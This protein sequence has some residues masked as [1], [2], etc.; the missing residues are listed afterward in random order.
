MSERK[1]GGYTVSQVGTLHLKLQ[2]LKLALLR[3]KTNPK[4]SQTEYRIQS[5]YLELLAFS[6]QWEDLLSQSSQAIL[7]C[8]KTEWNAQFYRYWIEALKETH[9]VEGLQRLGKH[10]LAL[11]S[12]SP[13]YQALACI[14]FVLCGRKKFGR[15]LYRD[16]VLSTWKTK[17]HWLVWEAM[18]VWLSDS[19]EEKDR[20][21]G[22]SLYLGLSKRKPNNYLLSR[23][24]LESALDSDEWEGAASVLNAMARA[25]PMAPEYPLISAKALLQSGTS[26]GA[27]ALL[28]EYS[29]VNPDN[30]EA[31][32]LL[33]QALQAQGFTIDAADLIHSKN[34]QFDP[35]DYDYSVELGKLDKKRF[36]ETNEEHFRTSAV[37]HL[38]YALRFSVR[39]GQQDG[40]LHSMLHEL[41][42]GVGEE[43]FV[44]SQ[45]KEQSPQET[46]I[47]LLSENL[48]RNFF[49]SDKCFLPAPSALRKGE[50][51][52]VATPHTELMGVEV[53]VGSFEVA[54]PAVPDSAFGC[55]VSGVRVKKL[56]KPLQIEL[57]N[58][59]YSLFDK[60]GCENF[61]RQGFAR[62]Y[63]VN[64]EVGETIQAKAKLAA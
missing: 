18:C 24:A 44:S 30:S 17:K 42:A 9:D 15:V 54:S 26:D 59:K 61:A 13:T 57:H 2:S 34:S 10:L 33:S 63:E 47:L 56:S 28:E 51:I 29:Y 1:E 23:G 35:D 31:I 46:K 6:L 40:V 12:V 41:N 21:K 27:L 25:F 4:M 43:V 8:E 49:S 64:S 48:A 55:G 19:P 32:L 53:I 11:R 16:M 58:L 60:W 14:S 39:I 45:D 3:L 52:F 50:I 37:R 36:E 5:E 38:A 7:R 22:V 20:L 62:F